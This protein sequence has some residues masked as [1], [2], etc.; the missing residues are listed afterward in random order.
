MPR[1]PVSNEVAK[2][3]V[4]TSLETVCARQFPYTTLW[5]DRLFTRLQP[6][7][8]PAYHQAQSC[9]HFLGP[10]VPSGKYLPVAVNDL[11]RV[12]Q[13]MPN[14][15]FCRHTDTAYVRDEQYT[16]LWTLLLYLND[17]VEGGER[18][19]YAANGDLAYIRSS[20]K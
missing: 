18:T 19:I 1:L 20:P 5:S 9:H 6:F 13:Y 2:M 17:D 16:G 15:Q 8:A 11:L 4:H 3:V 12:S 10:E 14:G 7:L